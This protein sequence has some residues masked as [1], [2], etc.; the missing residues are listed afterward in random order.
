MLSIVL[1]GFATNVLTRLAKKLNLSWT[2]VAMILAIVG[3][4]LFYVATNYYAVQWEMLIAFIWWVYATS[5]IVYNLIN[6]TGII[7][8][9]WQSLPPTPTV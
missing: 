9:L 1:I 6:K 8:K 7:D 2:Y 3:W 5:Q 4:S